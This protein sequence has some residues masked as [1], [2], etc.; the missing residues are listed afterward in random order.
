MLKRFWAWYE[1]HETLAIGLSAGLFVLQLVH[2]YW[3]STHVVFSR[4]FNI[5]LFNPSGVWELLIIVVDY[6][7]IPALVGVSLIYINQLRKKDHYFKNLL[8]LFFLNSQW[9]H[10]FWITDEF[11]ADQLLGSSLV[12]IPSGLAWLAIGIDYLELPVMV[13]TIKKFFTKARVLQ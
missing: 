12:G 7:E 11:V 13:D 9:I 10:I 1:K 6:T 2:L 4:L 5:S 3:L 8:Y